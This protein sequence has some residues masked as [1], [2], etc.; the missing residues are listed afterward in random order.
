[1]AVENGV[2]VP[3]IDLPPAVVRPHKR[4][5]DRWR[6]K[7]PPTKIAT[8][9]DVEPRLFGD[10]GFDLRP[11][12]IQIGHQPRTCSQDQQ[13]DDADAERSLAHGWGSPGWVESIIG[14]WLGSGFAPLG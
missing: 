13:Q 12:A 4:R 10:Q 1:M 11:E 9:F 3:L 8:D 14:D 6:R 5:R 2:V 7:Q